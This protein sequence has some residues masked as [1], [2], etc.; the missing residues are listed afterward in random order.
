MATRKSKTKTGAVARRMTKSKKEMLEYLH[1][2]PIV[3]VAA[4]RAGISRSTYYRWVKEDSKF[5]KAS[6][7]ARYE[8]TQMINDLAKSK[9]V[10]LIQQGNLTATIFWLKSRDTEFTDR[11]RVINEYHMMQQDDN[12][13]NI[14]E[15]DKQTLNEVFAMFDAHARRVE[16]E[17]VIYD[18]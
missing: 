4:K 9:L 8:G 1:K 12:P 14:P 10:E 11:R 16:P 3:E 17:Y 2:V 13:E 7:E 15:E 5:A 18:E 6:T